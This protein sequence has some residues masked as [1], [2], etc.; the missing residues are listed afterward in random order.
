MKTYEERMQSV[1]G[2]LRKK[3][4]Q[5]KALM[6]TAGVVC[7]CIIAGIVLPHFKDDND[8]QMYANNEYFKVIEAI[9]RDF[10]QHKEEDWK[11]EIEKDLW[12]EAA[13]V[14]PPAAAA[15]GDYGST[16]DLSKPNTALPN[17]SVEITDHQ[18]AGVLEADIIKRS[19]THIFYLDG[20]H[21]QVYPI[22]GED[23][24]LLC[25]WD[26]P[27]NEDAY[28]Y[29]NVE[30]YLSADATRINLVI[31][32]S[33]K[34]LNPERWDAFVQLI[35][36]DISDPENIK[37]EN[38]T[39]ISG[40]LYTVRMVGDQLIV[41]SNYRPENEIDFSKPETF[42]PHV[43]E[44]EELQPVPADQIIVPDKLNNLTYTVVT[45]LDGKTMDV[46]DSG[47]FM[48]YAS[49]IY[50]SQ[51]RI[52]AT[53][54]YTT[55]EF[56]RKTTNKEIY[57]SKTMTEIS[58]MNY[59]EEGFACAGTFK[60][61]GYVESQ[62]QMDEHEGIFRVVTETYSVEQQHRENGTVEVFRNQKRNANLYCFEVGTW[63]Q[64]AVIEDF[65]PEGETVESVRF[66]GDYAYVCTAVVVTLKDP[67]F[68]F[69][70]TDLNNI[71]VKD[72]G[73]IDGY[74]SSL[75]Q[76][77][78]D[79]L[80]GIGFDNDRTLKV[81]VYQETE[82]GV[83]SLCAFNTNIREFASDY[84]AYYI[85]REKNLFGIPTQ[86]GYL[87]LMF[88]GYQLA[89]LARAEYTGYVLYTRGVVVDH[90]LYV[91]GSVGFDVVKI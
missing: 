77:N 84:K 22:A 74:S 4:T 68:F 69:D 91:F 21:L 76:L 70:M 37:Q 1:Q 28:Y 56:V 11:F 19:Q 51:E 45:M 18:V 48:S 61:E 89:E 57:E 3:Q 31:S 25:T 75:I 10:P 83:Q 81:E 27:V 29:R 65:A 55:Q 47:A 90:Y 24:K 79:L 67:V 32:G 13:P 12:I 85:D 73:T 71:I 62:Y 82:T 20:P 64:K 8:I 35:S 58:C 40:N 17:G 46:I 63:E 36:L 87:L 66:D 7:L 50:V 86:G 78:D 49:R 60:V 41:V 42:L 6:A 39:Y 5:R 88:D 52:F 53:R 9:N 30:M 2:K 43:G 14:S 80:L 72:T 33:G 16:G 38:C 34:V 26:L 54:G 23:T 15:P 59:D 44:G